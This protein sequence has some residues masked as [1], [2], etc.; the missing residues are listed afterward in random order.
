MYK[1]LLCFRYLRTRY[2]A[3]V[4]IVSVMLGVATLIVVN[5]V[6]AGFSDKLKS[7]LNGLSSDVT[8][9]TE[10]AGGFPL[11]T[12]EIEQKLKDSPAGRYVE[13]TSPT[14]EAYAL[15]EFQL[16]TRNGIVPIVKHVKVIGIDPARHPKVGKFG[17]YLV[18]SKGDPASCFRMTEE[19]HWRFDA[20]RR[21]E[22]QDAADAE[23]AKEFITPSP[24]PPPTEPGKNPFGAPIP[25]IEP[26]GK[27]P[28]PELK[29]LKPDVPQPAVTA[30]P[31]PP[32]I[33]VGWDIGIARLENPDTHEMEDVPLLRPGDDLF[34]ATVGASGTK[35]V[36][37]T[38]V[39]TDYFRSRYG[40]YDA[41][42]V[43]VPLDELQRLRGM[44]DRANALQIRLTADV[45][46]DPKLVHSV[47]VPA[48][49]KVMP[50][51][52]AHAESWWQQQGS[53]LSAIDIERNLLNIL[54]FLIIGVAGFGVLAI[55]SMIVSEK[56]RDIGV[57]KS[58]GASGGGVMGIFLGYG[59]LLG[60]VGGLLGTGLGV[61]ITL[62]IND[63]EKALAAM[64]GREI[65]DRRVY[66]FDSI[67]THLDA[68]SVTLVNV[69]AVG[70]AVASAVLPA[71]RAARLQPVRALRFE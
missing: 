10:A 44:G 12:A 68:V 30:P 35:P 7:H 66:S 40:E 21:Q 6:M 49:Q 31:T 22:E 59:L 51:P 28:P 33:V 70:I 62:N 27:E 60:L 43:Y 69:G 41:N 50:A 45:R 5:S 18:N 17:D 71:L 38:F 8:V 34:L 20:H 48:A 52:E 39:V 67:P 65:F 42:I 53:L 2:L 14:V 4:C 64:T 9:R 55:F 37:A 47:V 32:G 13:A 16:R 57:L 26:D 29:N 25:Q 56:Y 11:E 23:R 36:S 1:L 58:L 63:I 61:W 3:F 15:L 46:E 19:A 54:L 24:A